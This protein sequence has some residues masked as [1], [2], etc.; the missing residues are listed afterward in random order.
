MI[1]AGVDVADVQDAPRVNLL[2]VKHNVLC[3]QELLCVISFHVSVLHE[4]S[5]TSSLGKASLFRVVSIHVRSL[6]SDKHCLGTICRS[7][8]EVSVQHASNM[9]NDAFHQYDTN[10]VHLIC[11]KQAQVT[12]P[13]PWA[14]GGGCPKDREQKPPSLWYEAP[15]KRGKCE[16]FQMVFHDTSRCNL[17]SYC[18]CLPIHECNICIHMKGLKVIATWLLLQWIITP[19]TQIKDDLSSSFALW[20][21]GLEN[22]SVQPSKNPK[23]TQKCLRQNTWGLIQASMDTVPMNTNSSLCWQEEHRLLQTRRKVQSEYQN[24]CKNC[25]TGTRLLHHPRHRLVKVHGSMC[26]QFSKQQSTMVHVASKA[27]KN[28]LE[29]QDEMADA[30]DS[31]EPI[32]AASL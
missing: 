22:A 10:S 19:T 28:S 14:C 25:S 7:K 1:P 27:L 6:S 30:Q 21:D 32:A 23:Q 12:A 8:T 26:L 24:I 2:R 4:R 17:A 20:L 9:Q 3:I 18:L 31:Q 16:L 5:V 15:T 13:S 29:I 11:G